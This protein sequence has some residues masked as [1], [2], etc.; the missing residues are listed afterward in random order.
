MSKIG[1]LGNSGL[2]QVPANWKD[3]ASRATFLQPWPTFKGKGTIGPLEPYGN[4]AYEGY[5]YPAAGYGIT[6]RKVVGLALPKVPAG[7]LTAGGWEGKVPQGQRITSMGTLNPRSDVFTKSQVA[8]LQGL[9]APVNGL[10]Y[11]FLRGLG[12]TGDEATIKQ[13]LADWLVG[14]PMPESLVKGI[15]DKLVADEKAVAETWQTVQNL[16]KMA[17][18]PKGVDIA[19]L[20]KRQEEAWSKL[21]TA[22]FYALLIPEFQ[23]RLGFTTGKPLVT[24]P[25]YNFIKDKAASSS[26]YSKVAGWLREKL[27]STEAGNLIKKGY[28]TGSLNGLGA[29][30]PVSWAVG[31]TLAVVALAGIAA[32]YKNGD[33][34]A[35]G[36]EAARIRAE[37]QK[38]L[39]QAVASG[40]L[41]AKEAADLNKS[42][43]SEPVPPPGGGGLDIATYAK[44][45]A[46]AVGVL[47][48]L[49]VVTAT[50][51]ALPSG[52]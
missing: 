30:D 28:M 14:G 11:G 33:A 21:N 9:A 6:R 32:W 19:A 5:G 34:Q 37:A 8:V 3:N 29:I 16:K 43:P 35:L 12:Q 13:K 20:Q 1:D 39:T 22:K 4:P 46:A 49:N 48:L 41:S 23:K 52:A 10:D 15:V 31:G 26:T 44:Y 51:Q 38:T 27:V 2:G 40:K 7:Q 42:M 47:I 24:K 50:K 45:G 18:P 36:N 25:D 17:K